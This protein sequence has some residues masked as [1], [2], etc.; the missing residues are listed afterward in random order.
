MARLLPTPAAVANW[1]GRHNA[2]RFA[3]SARAAQKRGRAACGFYSARCHRSNN[4]IS[5]A[6]PTRRRQYGMRK[7][8]NGRVRQGLRK[9]TGG[10]V[11]EMIARGLKRDGECLARALIAKGYQRGV[12]GLWRR[13]GEKSIVVTQRNGDWIWCVAGAVSDQR[14]SARRRHRHRSFRQ[15]RW[16][17]E[18]AGKIFAARSPRPRFI[19]KVQI[20][21]R[22]PPTAP[23]PK[24]Q[25]GWN[26]CDTGADC[27]PD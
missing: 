2:A 1:R 5:D 8:S 12:D 7:S 21:S 17:A 19:D 18:R 15:P 24:R 11:A 16:V 14:S 10:F 13:D 20:G 25:R 4:L 6:A 3:A 27:L 22:Q 23:R 26:G 9:P